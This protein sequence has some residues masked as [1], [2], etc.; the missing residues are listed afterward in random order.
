MQSYLQLHNTVHYITQIMKMDE[1]VNEYVASPVDNAFWFGRCRCIFHVGGTAMLSNGVLNPLSIISSLNR[2]A[3]NA[4]GGDTAVFMLLLHHMEKYLVQVGP[5][6]RW[7]K[8]ASA[9][10][11]VEDKIRLMSLL[12][13]ARIV[14]NYGLTEAMRTCLHPFQ[15]SPDKLASVGKPCPSVELRIEDS[16]GKLLGPQES[17]EVLIRGGNFASGYWKKPEMWDHKF[18]D[19]W[20][21]SGDV[22]YLD[23]EGFLHLRG[24]IDHAVNSGGKTIALSEVE[25]I[26]RKY[27][28]KTVFAVCGMKDPKGVLGEVVVLCVEQQWKEDEPWNKLRIHLFE[29]M[30]QLLVPVS[31]YLIPALPRTSNGKIQLNNLRAQIETG[32]YPNL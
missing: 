31:A 3:G 13:N 21:H 9:P 8:I 27:I 16:E 6:L 1:T 23:V 2:H 11:P 19:G 26:L 25:A 32:Q 4:I 29:A 30:E 5:S 17:G 22:G 14:M 18:R 7:V 15:D 20:Y 28:S 24:R 12:P 10:M